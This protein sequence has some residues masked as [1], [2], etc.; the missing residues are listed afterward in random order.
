MTGDEKKILI[1]GGS[2]YLGSAISQQLLQ[3][4]HGVHILD[5][6]PPAFS[7]PGQHF[8]R[9]GVGDSTVVK[10]SLDGCDSV[11]Y[12]A[13]VSDGRAGQKDPE[14]ARSSNVTHFRSFL[15]SLNGSIKRFI[16]ASTFGVYGNDYREPLTETLAV[17][18]QE[19]YSDSKVEAERLLRE[20]VKRMQVI[21]LRLAMAFGPAPRMRYDFIVNTM[22]KAAL[23]N[24]RIEVWGGRQRRPQIATGDVAMAIQK[25]L[26]AH[27]PGNY[28]LYN[29]GGSNPSLVEMARQIREAVNDVEIVKKPGRENENS[30]ELD[31]T[32]IERELG[33]TCPT[34]I[35]QAAAEMVAYLNK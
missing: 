13:G 1:T 16:F 17:N 6:M 29:L 3:S 22:L 26:D 23:E 35:T 8:F 10:E 12:L 28:N 25:L 32:K 2:G 24:G 7:H 34:T 11:I 18:P 27:L 21:V 30:F 14:A 31:S 15:G 5:I 19:P 20:T 33:I 9:G 4:G